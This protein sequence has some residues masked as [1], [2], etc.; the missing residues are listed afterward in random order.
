[1]K[2]LREEKGLCY[3]IY[4][5]IDRLKSSNYFYV[6]AEV[7]SDKVAL[8]IEEIYREINELK[9]TLVDEDELKMVKNYINGKILAGLDGPF[10]SSGLIKSY[11]SAE[12]PFAKFKSFNE[13]LINATPQQLK[14]VANKYLDW[15]QMTQVIVGP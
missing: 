2:N 15:D 3:N 9:Q 7:D 1:M 8:S 6:S 10:R 13:K 5:S 4:A 11:L 14:E 12:L